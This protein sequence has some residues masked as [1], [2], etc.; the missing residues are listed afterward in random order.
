MQPVSRV[1]AV[2]LL[3]VLV[4]ASAGT[5]CSRA[6]AAEP[7]HSAGCH[8]G[9]A[10]S[11]PQPAD[12]RCC[13]SRHRSALTTGIFSPRPALQALDAAAIGV[14]IAASSDGPLPAFSWPSGGPPRRL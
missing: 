12:Y 10:P 7:S 8:P 2:I 1:V 3:G 14:P 11:N 5:M 13:A 9:P 6:A 4:A